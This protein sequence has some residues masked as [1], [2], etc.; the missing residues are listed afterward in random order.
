MREI[1]FCGGERGKKESGLS[2]S[3]RFGSC[4]VHDGVRVL[5]LFT[6]ALI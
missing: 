3:A 6:F 4:R 2:G 1:N 5:Y